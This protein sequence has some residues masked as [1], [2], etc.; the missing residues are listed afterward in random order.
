MIPAGG[1]VQRKISLRHKAMNM[2]PST[3][4]IE[5][6][7]DIAVFSLNKPPVNAVDRRLVADGREGL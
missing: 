7:G 4:R 2:N 3:I 1:F 6:Q 5:R